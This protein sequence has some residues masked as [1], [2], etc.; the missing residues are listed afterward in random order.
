MFQAFHLIDQ[1]IS[2]RSKAFQERKHSHG[3]LDRAVANVT[4]VLRYVSLKCQQAGNDLIVV[5][6]SWVS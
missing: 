5:F 3:W 2:L 6:E 1:G 4:H